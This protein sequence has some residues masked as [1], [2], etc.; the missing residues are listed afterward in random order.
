MKSTTTKILWA[1]YL[2]ILGVL[3]PHTAWAFLSVEP[4][5]SVIVP[6][7]AALGFEAA[8]AVLTYKLAEHI[9][10]KPKGK[11]GFSLFLFRYVNAFSFGLGIATVISA[12]ANLAHAVE[13]GQTLKIFTQWGI[14]SGVYSL[15]FGGILPLVSL[16]FARVLSNVTEDEEAPNPELETAKVT[17]KELNKHIRESEARRTAAEDRAR[18]AEERFG[19]MGDLF[20]RIFSDDK[21]ERIIAVR[22]WKPK[23]PGSAIALITES[24]PAYVSE[25]LNT[26][27]AEAS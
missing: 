26:I 27:E 8:I 3:L 21:R 12:L 9:E 6:W 22:E 10:Q 23:L 17:I 1:V 25:V 11:K 16:T 5:G 2:C 19:A 13:F 15:A 4:S 20:R 7:L 14:P 18:L 24:S